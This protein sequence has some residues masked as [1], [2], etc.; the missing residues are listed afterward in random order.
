[1]SLAAEATRDILVNFEISLAIFIPNTPRNRA[2]SYT[3][4]LLT[5]RD[6]RTGTVSA[7]GLDSTDRAQRGPYR[8]D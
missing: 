8:K 7:R 4:I 2:I 3:Y 5:K 1:M 6:G